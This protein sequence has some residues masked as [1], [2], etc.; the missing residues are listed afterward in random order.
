MSDD[1]LRFGDVAGGSGGGSINY[2]PPATAAIVIIILLVGQP[3]SG[4]LGGLD[5]NIVGSMIAAVGG[6][7]GAT[8]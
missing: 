7:L 5:M 4:S 8:D 6:L 1:D 3:L 2:L